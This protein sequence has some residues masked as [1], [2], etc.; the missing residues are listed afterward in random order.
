MPRKKAGSYRNNRRETEKEKENGTTSHVRLP[1]G[2]QLLQG[3]GGAPDV[4]SVPVSTG[5]MA[6]KKKG[7]G[8]SKA[9]GGKIRGNGKGRPPGRF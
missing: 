4:R 5:K 9:A 3:G 8:K 2:G 1:V 6:K 7:Q